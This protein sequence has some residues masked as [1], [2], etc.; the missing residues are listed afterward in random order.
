MKIS[1]KQWSILCMIGMGFASCHQTNP[2]HIQ[3]TLKTIQQNNCKLT[4]YYPQIVIEEPSPQVEELNRLLEIHGAFEDHL[5]RCK[6]TQ[7][8]LTVVKGD[9]RVTLQ[10]QELLSIEF[11]TEQLF[12][13]VSDTTYHS[14]VL[15]PSKIDEGLLSYLSI[16]LG[17]LI[18]QLDRGDLLPYVRRYNEKKKATINLAAYKKGN[19]HAIVWGVS[20]RH[21]L[22]YV[23]GEGEFFGQDEIAIP[24]A[25]LE[26]KVRQK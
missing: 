2:Y 11:I 20:E 13:E 6:E 8:Q 18:P 12:G 9:F 7:E 26:Q 25:E 14:L 19:K 1:I 3:R 17:Q 4:L 24:L 23:G 21:L 16:E 22:L 15:N 10:S 5:R